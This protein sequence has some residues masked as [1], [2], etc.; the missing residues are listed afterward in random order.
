MWQK[1]CEK[2]C[3]NFINLFPIFFEEKNKNGY[4]NTYKNIFGGMICTSIMLAIN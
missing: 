2:K 4:L 3:K 1:F